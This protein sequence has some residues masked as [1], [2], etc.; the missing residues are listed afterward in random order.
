MGALIK[1]SG[2]TYHISPS[3]EPG[4]C[5]A[6][7]SCP[8]GEHYG[9]REAAQFAY[10]K[11][12]GTSNFSV[13]SK[14]EL[15]QDLALHGS[16]RSLFGEREKVRELYQRAYHQHLLLE[17]AVAQRPGDFSPEATD[18]LKDADVAI[19]RAV[20]FLGK[21]RWQALETITPHGNYLDGDAQKVILPP[22]RQLARSFGHLLQERKNFL[23]KRLDAHE[24][25]RKRFEYRYDRKEKGERA[26]LEALLALELLLGDRKDFRRRLG[27]W[28]AEAR[29]HLQ[30]L[31]QA[32][33]NLSYLEDPGKFAP[34]DHL[35][36]L[37]R[38]QAGLL[39]D[40]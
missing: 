6:V 38:A 25:A 7:H 14:S 29:D 12:M 1:R 2:G 20:E 15:K 39:A 8:F 21:R 22:T 36:E 11:Q 4:K 24:S 37:D 35:G 23:Q 5:R 18:E 3:G 16:I 33:R 26:E 9:S 40:F 13:A 27:E 17:R 30:N 31:E 19:N 34:K 32:S 10:E 28:S